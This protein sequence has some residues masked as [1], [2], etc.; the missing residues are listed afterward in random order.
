MAN[1]GNKIVLTLKEVTAPC[2][3]C[4]PSGN[5]KPNISSDP[6]YIPVQQDLVACPVTT[7]FTCPTMVVSGLDDEISYEVF[8]PMTVTLNPNAN[9]I[10]I[11]VM[12]D[13]TGLE[14][15]SVTT[16]LPFTPQSGYT[17]GTITPI[18]PGTYNISVDYLNSAN[19]VQASCE[20]LV[21][22]IIVT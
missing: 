1:T 2:P 20:D 7:D 21:E 18:T 19:V 9:K 15:N 12:D 5:T 17:S 6:D 8:V 16:N 22:L 4:T 13:V 11:R 3:P 14:V 10:K